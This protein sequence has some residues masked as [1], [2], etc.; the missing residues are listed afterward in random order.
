MD[1]KTNL[2]VEVENSFYHQLDEKHQKEYRMLI[3]ESEF[4]RKKRNEISEKIDKILDEY[5]V[6]CKALIT[7]AIDRLHTVKDNA[8]KI[9]NWQAYLGTQEYIV[10]CLG[11]LLKVLEYRGE[12]RKKKECLRKEKEQELWQ[13][14]LALREINEII[15][16]WMFGEVQVEV[17]E[18]GLSIIELFGRNTERIVSAI[19]FWDIKDNKDIVKQIECLDRGETYVSIQ[20]YKETLESKIK[21]YFYTE[22][23]QERYLEMKLYDWIRAYMYFK[24]IALENRGEIYIS[25]SSQKVKS[26][27]R[28]EGFSSNEIDIILKQFRFSK[29]KKD[30]FDSFLIPDGEQIYFIPEIFDFI[31]PSRAMLSLFGDDE[32]DEKKSQ[33][34]NKGVA[35]ENHI[36]EL[37]NEKKKIN[38]QKNI[39]ANVG[40]EAYEVDIVFELDGILFFVSVRHSAN[41][42]I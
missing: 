20:C 26:D 34:A 15:Q 22:D 19:N 17:D 25:I 7:T 33:I 29:E 10:F 18:K 39:L 38:I 40:E 1:S 41:I 8:D 23:F 6:D 28:I 42:K 36:S 14:T 35:F 27:L 11:S 2:R 30:L 4:M 32:S 21:E 31:D 5:Y 24:T 12:R 3:K 13:Y 9:G 16:S 37:V